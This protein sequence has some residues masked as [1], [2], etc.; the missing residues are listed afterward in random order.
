MA[1]QIGRLF[2]HGPLEV[3]VHEEKK[4]RSFAECPNRPSFLDQSS[5]SGELSGC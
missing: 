5:L 1:P 4:K 2:L 3:T